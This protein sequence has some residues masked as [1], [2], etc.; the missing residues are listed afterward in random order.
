[1]VTVTVQVPGAEAFKV[2]AFDI[3]HD[4]VPALISAYVNVPEPEPPVVTNASPLPNVPRIDVRVKLSC[5]DFCTIGFSQAEI[6][7]EY[8]KESVGVS[9]ADNCNNPDADGFQSQNADVDTADTVP[10]PGME[11]PP[12]MKFTVPGCDVVAV[13]RSM[14][15][16]VGDTSANAMLIVVGTYAIES[17]K[18]V[19]AILTGRASVT[20]TLRTDDPATVGVPVIAPVAAS[21]FSPEGNEPVNTYVRGA[22]PPDPPTV[23]AK[24]LLAVPDKPADGV[25]ITNVGGLVVTE[26]FE[27]S[28][29]SL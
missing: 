21:K 3:E 12:T 5:E 25:E 4:A 19:V 27:L 17:V 1:M 11:T 8:A 14:L 28:T 22:I 23:K 18:L 13:I 15:L 7:D 24:A 16:Y 2:V 20:A 29:E 6:E 26:T 10:H 9:V